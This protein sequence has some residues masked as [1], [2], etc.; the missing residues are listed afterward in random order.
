[1]V[2]EIDKRTAFKY[3]CEIGSELIPAKDLEECLLIAK[4]YGPCSV[5]KLSGHVVSKYSYVCDLF[6]DKA[7]KGG[8]DE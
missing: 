4:S 6:I 2:N 3:M 8:D 7:L 1:M 5:F